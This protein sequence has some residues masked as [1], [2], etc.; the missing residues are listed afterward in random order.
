LGHFFFDDLFKS[1]VNLK[2][3]INVF[4]KTI[5]ITLVLLTFLFG[6]RGATQLVSDQRS[7]TRQKTQELTRALHELDKFIDSANAP[8]FG[9]DIEGRV[10]EWNSMTA[11]ITGYSKEEAL[12]KNLVETYIRGDHKESVSD[13][14]ELA[15]TGESTANYEL[16]LY[17]RSGERIEVLL[18]A[19]TRRD[20][21]GSII[22]AIGVGQDI[23]ALR[24]QEKRL[25]QAEKMEAVG[26]LTGGIAHDFNNLLA[27]IQGNLDL[28]LDKN[29][30]RNNSE[31]LQEC[32]SDAA[33]ATA[34]ATKLTT[35][36][37]SFA[38]QQSFRHE[39]VNLRDL[40]SGSARKVSAV[41]DDNVE[42][43]LDV[44]QCDFDVLVDSSQLEISIAN[45]LENAK[46]AVDASGTISLS[47]AIESFGDP[48][49]SGYSLQAGEYIVVTVTDDGCG[50]EPSILSKVTGPFYT[51]RNVGEGAGLGLS[52]IHGFAKKANGQ[53]R[54][55]SELGVGTRVDLALP[56]LL[57]DYVSGEGKVEEGEVHFARQSGTVLIVEDEDRLR[58]LASR[59]LSSTGFEV[60]EAGNPTEALALLEENRGGVKILFSDIRMPGD[61]S[62]RDLADE[63]SKL[64]PDIR[65]LLATGYE[66][67]A[68]PASDQARSPGSKAPVLRKPY[69]RAELIGAV[70]KLG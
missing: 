68:T 58:K 16:P 59:H 51:T 12:G 39:S 50:I 27:V 47:V 44:D 20:F 55:Q 33:A 18:N 3:P 69:S 28:V 43:S 45:L 61:L 46:Y 36:L 37:L 22:G 9:V 5:T 6:L 54:L 66:E 49:D 4:G 64:Y 2:N 35:R 14:I 8:I 11:E 41:F 40:V 17:S 29:G 60:I 1:Q 57:P 65:T 34:D 19:V 31:F 53:L 26:H 62:G 21:E 13:V 52:M 38:S 23:T 48:L 63:V 70:I 24:E 10:N 30:S 67:E 7:Y 56:L 32:L 42:L 15:L 25:F